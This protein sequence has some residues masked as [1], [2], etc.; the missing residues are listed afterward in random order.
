M[1]CAEI[2]Q[3]EERWPIEPTPK[4][5]IG[6]PSVQMQS[7]MSGSVTIASSRPLCQSCRLKT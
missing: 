6:Q 3:A 2:I 1:G 4:A 5:T 7:L